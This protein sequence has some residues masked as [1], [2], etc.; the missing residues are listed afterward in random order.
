MSTEGA[1]KD[2]GGQQP[3]MLKGLDAAA[4]SG[5]VKPADQSMQATAE[6]APKPDSLDKEERDAAE[7]LKRN[8][9]RDTGKPA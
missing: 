9:E 6:T 5:G 1:A 8:A 7:I 4:R 3:E 2:P